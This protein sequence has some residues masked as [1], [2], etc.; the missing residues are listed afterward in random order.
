MTVCLWYEFGG[1]IPTTLL[2]VFPRD[3]NS[4]IKGNITIEPTTVYRGH[5]SVVGVCCFKRYILYPLTLTLP[6]YRT[7]T[8]TAKMR[9]F[10]RA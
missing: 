3:L 1:T 7:L 5:S 8:G 4:Y 10:L 2:T 6:L 9:I